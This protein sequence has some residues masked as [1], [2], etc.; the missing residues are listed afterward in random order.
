MM[1]IK[2]IIAAQQ[3]AAQ[4]SKKPNTPARSAQQI[5]KS[6]VDLIAQQRKAAAATNKFNAAKQPLPPA[7]AQSNSVKELIAAQQR[8]AEAD[9]AARE[10]RV[11]ANH[12]P[13]AN[14]AIINKYRAEYTKF[15]EKLE[16]ETA[17]SEPLLF[18]PNIPKQVS[19]E[20]VVEV[21][22]ASPD[23]N[24]IS[25]GEEAGGT[26]EIKMKPKRPRRPKKANTTAV[27]EPEVAPN[28]DVVVAGSEV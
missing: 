19:A 5:A 2:E 1:S 13:K 20:T 7:P 9:K 16:N 18:T 21:K 14:E 22:E 3:R 26:V 23:V 4:A 28:S 10:A 6:T 27:V 25:V 8:A 17:N 15:L 24:G 11:N 12:N